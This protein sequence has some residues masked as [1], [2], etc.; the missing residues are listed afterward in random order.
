MELWKYLIRL[1]DEIEQ[2]FWLRKTTTRY[3]INVGALTLQK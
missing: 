2:T 3:R 1:R